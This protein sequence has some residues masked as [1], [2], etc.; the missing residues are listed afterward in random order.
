MMKLLYRFSVPHIHY[1]QFITE[2]ST[3][4]YKLET[5]FN[6]LKKYD[7]RIQ[8][9]AKGLDLCVEVK[10]LGEYNFT[11][12]HKDRLVFFQSPYQMHQ[13]YFNEVSQQWECV[14]DKHYLIECLTRET[15]KYLKG[16]LEF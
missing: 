8:V 14:K 16:Y 2:A 7:N 6:N 9:Q 11:V 5:S 12:H 4:L 3:L 15:G 1:D 10:D 13:Y